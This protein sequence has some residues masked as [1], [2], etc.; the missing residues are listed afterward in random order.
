[1][2]LPIDSSALPANATLASVVVLT[3]PAG[4]SAYEPLVAA[5][6]AA[7][8]VS[9]HTTH[10]STFVPAVPD[11]TSGGMDAAVDTGMDAAVDTDATTSDAGVSCNYGGGG[12]G[13]PDGSTTCSQFKRCGSNT[14]TANCDETGAGTCLVNGAPNGT[15]FACSCGANGMSCNATNEGGVGVGTCSSACPF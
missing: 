9:A 7:S 11:A 5:S 4:S 12:G 13:G 15:T 14:Y 1:M 2:T 10:F 8:K 6:A 3:A